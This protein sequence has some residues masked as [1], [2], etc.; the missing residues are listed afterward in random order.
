MKPIKLKIKGINSF[1]DEQ[2][3]DFEKL[4][5]CGIF[6]IFGPTGSGK[7]SILDAMTLALYDEISRNT[8]EFINKEVDKAWVYF[9]F[10]LFTSNGKRNFVVERGYKKNK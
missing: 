6:G 1:I 10:S 5:E 9:E 8:R 4:T 2:I 7:S 3:I